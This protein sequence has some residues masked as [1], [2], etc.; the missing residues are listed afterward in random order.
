MEEKINLKFNFKLIE[1]KERGTK[2]DLTIR[3]N[4]I[5][6]EQKKQCL[7]NRRTLKHVYI[8]REKFL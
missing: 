4:R 3:Q 1:N 7:L 6:K 2:N 8:K 5:I